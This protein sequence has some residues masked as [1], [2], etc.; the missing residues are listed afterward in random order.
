MANA[1]CAESLS[2]VSYL[3]KPVIVF[4]NFEELRVSGSSKSRGT[5]SSSGLGDLVKNVR[6]KESNEVRPLQSDQSDGGEPNVAS[7]LESKTKSLYI[8]SCS[9]IGFPSLLKITVIRIPTAHM[10]TLLE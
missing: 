1:S 8:E 9:K 7:I 3:V 2:L 6:F 10:S 4:C 5:I